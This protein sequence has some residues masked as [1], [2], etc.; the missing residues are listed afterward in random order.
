MP[1]KRRPL[2][3]REVNLSRRGPELSP[4]QR[5]KIVGAH[6]AGKTPRELELEFNVSR[7][8][9]RSTLAQD[10]QRNDGVSQYRPGRKK[11]YTQRDRR[12]MLKNL[13][14]H[15]KLTF[16]QRRDAVGLKMSDTY[17]KNLAKANGLTHWRAKGRPELTVVHAAERLLWC[18]VRAH[19]DVVR[20]KSYC[21]SDE[22]SAERGKGQ[23]IEW[24]WGTPSDK[25]K[26]SHVTTYKAG[27]QLRV[28]VWAA[29]WGDGERCKLFVLERDWESKKHGYSAN[30]YLEV[31][32]KRL[33]DFYHDDL[34]FMQDNAPIHRA[35]KVREWFNE[36]GIHI[37]DWPPYSPDLNP[38]EHC[39]K[40]LKV[41]TAKM[42]PGIWESNGESEEDLKNLEEALCTAWDALPNSLFESLVESMPR[43]IQACIE[44]DGWHTKY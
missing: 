35:I 7:G 1:P 20:W 39:W 27:K 42:F 11:I 2:A 5:G 41:L 17:I 8:A 21:W 9:I 25:W 37:T 30:S 40:A 16:E 26:P 23:E 15:P 12:M 44:A 24:V 36:N 19:W 10:A 13:R 34:I 32:E 3:E 14:L 6:L 4:Y 43:R 29:F 22:C 38:I 31:L 33:L 18:R 28:M